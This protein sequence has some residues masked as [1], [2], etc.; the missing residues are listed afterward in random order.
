MCSGILLKG[1][2]WSR[3]SVLVKW[4]SR[5]ILKCFSY[6]VKNTFLCKVESPRVFQRIQRV[7]V[8]TGDSAAWEGRRRWANSTGSGQVVAP[9]CDLGQVSSPLAL[10]CS[11]V[12]QEVTISRITELLWKIA[13]S[14]IIFGKVIW[15]WQ[16]YP[17]WQGIWV[18]ITWAA[19][20]NQLEFQGKRSSA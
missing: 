4:D 2:Q 5:E 3:L 11:C 9:L 18:P 20:F 14:E 12:K 1:A 10:V 16:N 6:P 8:T 19:I 15:K 17:Q 7:L 13:S